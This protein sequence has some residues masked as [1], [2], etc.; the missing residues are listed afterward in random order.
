MPKYVAPLSPLEVSLNAD[1]PISTV[2]IQVKIIWVGVADVGSSSTDIEP[3][4]SACMM[5]CVAEHPSCA[6]SKPSF[7]PPASQ[8]FPTS[9]QPL[10]G[11]YPPF[12]RF[13][14]SQ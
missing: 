4:A 1:A 7:E 2:G 6:E 12:R 8:P 10:L 3:P 14:H 11:P 13:T 9:Q 5:V